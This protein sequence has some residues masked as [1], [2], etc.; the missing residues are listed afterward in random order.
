M[1]MGRGVMKMNSQI[2]KHATRTA[3]GH[4]PDKD[5]VG[6]V[7][8]NP[9]DDTLAFY[10]KRTGLHN[11]KNNWGYLCLPEQMTVAVDTYDGTSSV[12]LTITKKKVFS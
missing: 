11:W 7:R 8:L 10:Y 4:I 12:S 1:Q 2:K 9:D 6:S 3:I 5:A